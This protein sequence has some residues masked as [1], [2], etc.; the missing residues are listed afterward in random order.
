MREGNLNLQIPINETAV[1]PFD[2]SYAG[3]LSAVL[4]TRPEVEF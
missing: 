1:A 2:V 4:K 3:L